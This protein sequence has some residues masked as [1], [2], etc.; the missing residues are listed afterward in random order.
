[1]TLKDKFLRL[2]GEAN[3]GQI[4]YF[5][6]PEHGKKW[7][8]AFNGQSFRRQIFQELVASF[9]FDAIIE[10][11]TYRGVTTKYMAE[12]RL[13]LHTVEANMR[14]LSYA[15]MNIRGVDEKVRTY[16]SDSRS[17]LR[18]LGIQ[19]T[20]GGTR[21]FVYLDA[22]WHDDLPLR[23]EL[24]IV[25]EYWPDAV[26]MIDDFAVPD[27]GYGYDDYGCGKTLNLEY[28]APL[29]PTSLQAFFPAVSE[30]GETGCRRGSVVLAGGESAE[31]LRQIESLRFYV[32]IN[33]VKC[34]DAPTSRAA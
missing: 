13:P 5:I 27:T 11:G 22:H 6:R 21:P 25:Q 15:R 2:V 28:L 33:D 34:K 18:R 29:A 30:A 17:F 16:H 3:A 31:Q 4:E 12:T 26:V 9:S 32:A 8:G 10:T 23:E 14:Y 19:G 1:M 7:G 24:E 20:V